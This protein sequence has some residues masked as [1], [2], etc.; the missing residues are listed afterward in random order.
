MAHHYGNLR[1]I[2][3]LIIKEQH[4]IG[5]QRKITS[6]FIPQSNSGLMTSINPVQCTS[7]ESMVISDLN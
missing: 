5:R 3:E 2:K 4:M 6:F 7:Q 1:M